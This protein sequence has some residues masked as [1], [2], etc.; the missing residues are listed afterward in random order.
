MKVACFLRHGV[1]GVPY[2]VSA[3]D[4]DEMSLVYSRLE[5]WRPTAVLVVIVYIDAI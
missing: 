1:Y 5:V 4:S 3:D 2:I